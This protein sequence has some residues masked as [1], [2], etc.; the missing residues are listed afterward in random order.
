MQLKNI[1]FKRI[2]LQIQ[3]HAYLAQFNSRGSTAKVKLDFKR[4][5]RVDFKIK[6][7]K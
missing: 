6:M 2:F 1:M 3:T 5:V 7:P 4:H